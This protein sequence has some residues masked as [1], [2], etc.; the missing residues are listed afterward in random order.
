MNRRL[1]RMAA[2]AAAALAACSS[3][4]EGP[5]GTTTLIMTATPSS[6]VANGK[7]TVL[8]HVEGAT[9]A[10]I[11]IRT[12][13]GSFGGN[14]SAQADAL[15]GDFTL[16][17][18]DTSV[19]SSCGGS[20]NIIATD[21]DNNAG[22]A[23]LKFGTLAGCPT[24]CA[25]D[26]ACAGVACT[27][28]GGA[29]GTCSASPAACVPAVCTSTETTETSCM[30]GIDNDCNGLVDGADTAC[31]GK[32]C[33]TDATWTWKSGACTQATTGFA[34]SVVPARTRLPA[35]GLATTTV[36]VT[37]KNGSSPAAGVPVT[38]TATAGTVPPGSKNTAADGTASFV[39][40]APSTAALATLTAT[41][42]PTGVTPV[43]LTTTITMP[44]LGSLEL[45][46]MTYNVMG[47]KGSAYQE[48]NQLVV[49]ALDDEGAP[50]PD[51]LLVKFDHISTGGSAVSLALP[52]AAT[53]T[54][55]APCNTGANCCGAYCGR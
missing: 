14:P 13:R 35:D 17:T 4:P 55:I 9:K 27:T 34:I 18:C 25:L 23:S 2:L 36:L 12:T 54:A 8:L 16:T 42:A 11:V 46:S 6:V 32:Q 30:D 21:A 44:A 38:L 50:Y 3:S 5:S 40:T 45:G 48:Q 15:S 26:A 41:A 28:T 53:C 37:V 49:S 33:K 19:D 47:V 1:V 24:N 43:S 22:H 29:A 39:F 10:P 52:P 51:G 7:N 31:E 20:F